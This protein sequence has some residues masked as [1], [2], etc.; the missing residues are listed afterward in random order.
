MTYST[1]SVNLAFAH[2]VRPQWE[3]LQNGRK[4]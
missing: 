3:G 1:N 4:H 2:P